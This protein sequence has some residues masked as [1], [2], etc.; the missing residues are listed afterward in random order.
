M[1]NKLHLK[2]KQ[3]Q[4]ENLNKPCVKEDLYHEHVQEKLTI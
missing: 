2:N 1:R 3:G 4:P